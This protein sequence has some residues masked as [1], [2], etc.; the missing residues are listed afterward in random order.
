MFVKGVIVKRLSLMLC[1]EE[2]N[3]VCQRIVT[4]ISQAM[5]VDF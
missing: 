4:D 1:L 2:G 5:V 3:N